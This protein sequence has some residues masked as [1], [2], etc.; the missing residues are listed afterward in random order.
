MNF[1]ELYKFDENIC[2]SILNYYNSNKHLCVP[3]MFGDEEI[4]HKSKESNDLPIKP[5]NF[6]VIESYLVELKKSL[7]KYIKTHISKHLKHWGP[8]GIVEGINIQYYPPNGGY[9]IYHTE[10]GPKT[11]N[12]E[13]VFM[14]YLTNTKNGGTHFVNQNKTFEC[15]KGDTLI[16]PADFTH[17][18]KGVI[19]NEEKII[20][21]G[22]FSFK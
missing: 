15:I 9:K 7:Q 19:S 12:R 16:W 18:H 4:N 6:I 3:G 2:D 1:I 14:T 10:R 22:W 11:A 13:L 8:I 21:T 5:E 17:I 20:I